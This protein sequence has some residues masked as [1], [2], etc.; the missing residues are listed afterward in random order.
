MKLLDAILPFRVFFLWEAGPVPLPQTAPSCS[1]GPCYPHP[2]PAARAAD[3]C[4]HSSPK[5]LLQEQHCAAPTAFH[6]TPN[7]ASQLIFPKD[8][9]QL[10]PISPFPNCHGARR[11]SWRQPCATCT[12]ALQTGCCISRPRPAKPNILHLTKE[13]EGNLECRAALKAA[14]AKAALLFIQ[15]TTLLNQFDWSLLENI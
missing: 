11:P 3:P 9:R 6:W 2:A 14:W 10:L 4:V 1:A 12:E 13:C 8:L 5:G 15:I 7:T